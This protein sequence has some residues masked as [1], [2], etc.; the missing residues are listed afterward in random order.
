MALIQQLSVMGREIAFD[1]ELIYPLPLD[2]EAFP[3][4]SSLA[5]DI[6]G[7]CNLNCTYCAESMTLPKRAPMDKEVL[8]RSIEMLFK[9]SSSGASL[10]IV[11]GSGEPL[12]QPEL[13]K[14][15][16]KLARRLARKTNRRLSLF[17]TTNG[18]LLDSQITKWLIDDAWEVKVSLDGPREIHD[19]FRRDSNGR[20]TFDRIRRQVINLLKKIPE[21]VSTTAVLCKGSDPEQIYNE[22]AGLGVRTIELVPLAIHKDSPFIPGETEVEKYREFI[23]SY[24]ERAVKSG[25]MPVITRFQTR[26]KRVMG[27]G[28]RQVACWAGRRFFAA[29]PDG[30][31]YPCYRFIGLEEFRLGGI[32]EGICNEALKRFTINGARPSSERAQCAKC[33]VSPLCD[34]PCFACTE[35]IG[36]GSPLPGFCEMMIAD[37]EAVLWLAETLRDREP[38]RLC[39]LAGI[40]WNS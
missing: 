35:L 12:L 3:D 2:E 22:I 8:V 34:G 31:L 19:R 37:C 29:G 27:I 39:R 5:I 38:E 15:A 18:T 9:S 24:A 21:R 13:V 7:S 26:L 40:E 32:R 11:F 20:G 4:I 23:F 33:W 36:S 30:S 17:L 1:P 14:L 10:S 25:D 6:S 28:N 16:G